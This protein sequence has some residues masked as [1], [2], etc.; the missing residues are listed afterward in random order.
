MRYRHPSG[1]LVLATLLV[2]AAEPASHA[3]LPERHGA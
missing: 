1:I 2:A 3:I